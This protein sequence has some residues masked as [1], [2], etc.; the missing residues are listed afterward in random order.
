[1][2]NSISGSEYCLTF[3]IEPPTAVRPGVSFILPVIVAVR[4]ISGVGTDPFQQL[5][6][7]IS[8]RD[9]TG[10]TTIAGLN[11][12]VTSSVRSQLGNTSNGYARF[13][14]LSIANPGRYVLRV[15]LAVN[16]FSGVTT[17]AV[18][19]SA[20]IHVHAE[21]ATSQRPSVYIPHSAAQ[22]VRLQGLV[23]EN[24]D[25]SEAQIAAWQQA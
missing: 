15:I 12:S 22:V 1:M 14:P 8:L 5:G 10:T 4:R 17:R 13:G 24:I 18:I 2:Q 23:S 25:I 6:A 7:T 21:A 9:E 16:T 20:A 11:G 3:M 19:D